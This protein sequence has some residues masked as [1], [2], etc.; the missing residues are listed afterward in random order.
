MLVSF[1]DAQLRDPVALN[2]LRFRAVWQHNRPW[3]L[4][5]RVWL[6]YIFIMA[7]LTDSASSVLFDTVDPLLSYFWLA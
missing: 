5:V 2:V 1:F 7:I 6:C 3:L 4:A